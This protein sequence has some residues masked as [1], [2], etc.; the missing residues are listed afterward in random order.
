MT[1]GLEIRPR[2]GQ[3]KKATAAVDVETPDGDDVDAAST[4]S[5]DW[6][7]VG[8]EDESDYEEIDTEG[9][10]E[11]AFLVLPSGRWHPSYPASA[12]GRF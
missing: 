9:A 5:S 4:S 2:R 11:P 3:N 6:E 12:H 1:T 10:E 7:T 8:P